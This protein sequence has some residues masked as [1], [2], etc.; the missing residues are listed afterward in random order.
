[1]LASDGIGSLA[2]LE[3]VLKRLV[4]AGLFLAIVGMLQFGLGF[5]PYAHLQIPGFHESVPVDI[6]FFGPRSFFH[7]AFGSSEQ[8]IEYAAVLCAILPLALHFAMHA[9]PKQRLRSWIAPMVILFGIPLSVSRTAVIGLVIALTVLGAT[10]TWRQ[11]VNALAV[12][13]VLALGVRAAVPGLVGTLASL[14]VHL[15]ESDSISGRTDRYAVVGR[16]VYSSPVFGYGF[17]VP[18]PT[19]PLVDNE[20]LTTLIQAGAVALI[21]L[22]VLLVVGWSMARRARR[23]AGGEGHR[24]LAQALA[25][26]IAVSVVTFAAYDAL[27]FRMASMTLFL[28]LGASGA[29]WR[30]VDRPSRP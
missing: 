10:W 29:L 19:L 14:F 8:P 3:T 20:Y 1:L 5:N 18:Q 12:G 6:P 13:A 16:F 11:R 24:S 26:S 21:G 25:A 7:R 28:V 4:L 27:S 2:R 30:L 17:K 9:P 22:I 23:R 15:G